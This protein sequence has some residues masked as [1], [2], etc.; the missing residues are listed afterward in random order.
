MWL[1]VRTGSMGVVYEKSWPAARQGYNLHQLV[2][3]DTSIF[4]CSNGYKFV[5]TYRLQ[6]TY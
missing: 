1:H 6:Y 5:H 2:G 4:A 3:M